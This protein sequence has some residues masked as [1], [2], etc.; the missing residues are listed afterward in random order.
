MA[1]RPDLVHGA[2]STGL[3]GIPQGLK[4]GGRNSGSCSSRS[5]SNQWHCHQISGP[6]GSSAEEMAWLHVPG[7]ARRLAPCDPP[8]LQT[9]TRIV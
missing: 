3:Q 2:L 9:G 1:Q 5:Q 8:S 4:F 7:L 6:V